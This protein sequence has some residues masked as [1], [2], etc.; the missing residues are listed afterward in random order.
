MK[1]SLPS[2]GARYWGTV[3]LVAAVYF[4]TAKLG[5]LLAS[6][7][8]NVTLFWPPAGIGLAALI[9]GGWRLL[10]A[11]ALG[12][13][14]A[15][16]TTGASWPLMLAAVLG[17]SAAGLAGLGL[18][19]WGKVDRR[20][21]G[22]RDIMLLVLLGG[23]AAS[24]VSASAGTLGL[25]WSNA[26]PRA[27]WASPWLTWWL[28]DSIGVMTVTP[29]V[30]YWAVRPFT[31]LRRLKPLELW[32]WAAAAAVAAIGLF[33]GWVQPHLTHMLVFVAF[34]LMLWA[35]LRF[36]RRLTALCALVVCQSTVIATAAG[37]GPFAEHQIYGGQVVLWA[38]LASLTVTA[39][40]LAS[41]TEQLRQ[42]AVRLS[43]HRDEL[44]QAVE[45][46]TA[47]L[48][49]AH[50]ELWQSHQR[51][52]AILD[53]ISDGFFTLDHDLVI[54]YFNAAAE[55]LVKRRAQEVLG[56]SFSQAFPEAVGS[57]LEE[58]YRRAV[59][60]KIPLAFETFFEQEPYRNW[61]DVR[62]YPSE[63]GASVFFR[64]TTAQKEAA[65]ALSRSEERLR[66]LVEESPLGVAVLSPEGKYLYINP[67]FTWIFG[68]TLEDIPQG[69]EWFQRAF[70]DQAYRRQ[71]IEA[72]T[73]GLASSSVGQV[74][75]RTFQ[76]TCNSGE[77]KTVEFRPVTLSTGEQLVIYEDVSDREKALSALKASEEK[78]SKVFQHSPLWVVLSTL[79]EG[80]LLEVN[81]TF[82][83]STGF[84]R[85]EAT[86]R[87]ILELGV[88]P[89]DRGRRKVVDALLRH[90]AV[91]GMEVR[92][93]TKTGRL[94]HMLYY[95]TLIQVGGERLVLSL[96]QD[97][98][99]RKRAEEALRAS[100]EK[101]QKLYMASPVWVNLTTLREG[102]YLEVNDAF[103]QVTGY[104]RQEAIGKT[105]VE[106][107]LWENPADRR[108]VR[109][110]ILRNGSLRHF[111]INFKM[112]DGRVRQFLWSAEMA[113]L[114]P[115][116][117][118]ISA[119]L[120]ITDLRQAQ[121]ALAQ[122]EEQYRLLV[123]HLQDAVYILQDNRFVFANPEVEHI[124]G[125]SAEELRDLDFQR[126]L[127]P[128][129]RKEVAQRYQDP[130]AGRPA[131]ESYPIR[132]V[133]KDG[134]ER[135]IQVKG[136]AITWRERPALLYTARDITQQRSMEAQL[137]QSQKLEAVGTLAGGIA[138]DFNNLLAAVMGYAEL[139]L[140]LAPRTA[141]WCKTWSRYSRPARGGGAW[142]SR[143]SPSAGGPSGR[144][145]PW[146]WPS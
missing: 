46:R 29:L 83:Q 42:A 66:T 104:S 116:P 113:E 26:I 99:E 65:L 106:L 61:F 80:R 82:L 139:S 119:H 130:L 145:S 126:L 144:W 36:G 10:P 97:I 60:E 85:E 75:P 105:S 79:E 58:Q 52:Q 4:L 62:I 67:Q 86:G 31:S 89:D 129:Y 1:A 59:E 56:L 124:T 20:L 91:S 110:L 7:Q 121:E 33:G 19:G 96:L 15:T 16:A 17:N 87:T 8:G 9:L 114:G 123:N 81:Q 78:F 137:R 122:S 27:L 32:G 134:G 135:W 94:R 38:Y 92:M 57:I 103:C 30:L 47:Q 21:G 55:R 146:T 69:R 112:K 72:W 120:D 54:T 127:H 76:V 128:D 18:L 37:I 12:T 23:L 39:L 49:S 142:C 24:L 48:V 125:Y 2:N 45:R 136:I 95:G 109:E 138:H 101:F 6:V 108:T 90:G 3:L 77:T 13:W 98:T 141:S 100:E 63:S 14:A 93:R 74:R 28:G 143:C 5:M 117:V 11:V 50:Q 51:S 102:R 41:A 107:G 131:P 111:P 118:I 44:A 22:V 84:T 35:A 71:A 133:T 43:H 64:V 40:A 115:E 68:Y 88:I 132:L 25:I 34:P 140:D 70:P 53:S 73:R